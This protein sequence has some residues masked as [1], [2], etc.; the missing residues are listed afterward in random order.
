VLDLPRTKE[1]NEAM[2]NATR[3]KIHSAAIKLFSDKGFTSTSV[4]EIVDTAGISMG[5]LYRHYKTK[6]EI[7]GALVK[8]A[9]DGLEQ[10]G[11]TFDSNIQPIEAISMFT[12]EI[13]DDF[14]KNE[15]FMQYMMLMTQPFLENLQY[16]WMNE[17][18]ER[19]AYMRSRFALLI[20]KGQ[21]LGQF[22]HGDPDKMTQLFFS[23]I[24][25]MCIMKHFL[26]ESFNPPT[27]DMMLAYILIREEE[28]R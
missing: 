4:Q 27:A 1:Q 6:D 19:N 20:E 3:V 15:E 16:P 24:Q 2:R 23:M 12:N 28:P 13:I 10:V 14:S 21:E 5:L 8:E 26:K 17:L 11:N 18:F 9:L 7:F 25:G 22:K